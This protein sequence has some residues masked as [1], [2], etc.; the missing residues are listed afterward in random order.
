MH[1]FSHTDHHR[2]TFLA[3][4]HGHTHRMSIM[5]K[6]WAW[7]WVLTEP[8]TNCSPGQ[9]FNHAGLSVL[10]HKR[11]CW[12][13]PGRLPT[14]PWAL[15]VLP[16]GGRSRIPTVYEELMTPLPWV[17]SRDQGGLRGSEH[18]PQKWAAQHTRSLRRDRTDFCI[19]TTQQLLAHGGHLR[20]GTSEATLFIL[21]KYTA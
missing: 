13:S 19:P 17:G 4:G 10:N 9:S 5:S 20:E 2:H 8:H 7:I 1:K 18:R 14:C 15:W 6:D 3:N 12:Y 16:E 21:K 11:R